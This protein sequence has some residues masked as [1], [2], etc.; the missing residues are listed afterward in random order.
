MQMFPLPPD[1]IV[2][3]NIKEEAVRKKEAALKNK[4]KELHCHLA[5]SF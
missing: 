5:F 1:V 3:Q 2:I 4:Y